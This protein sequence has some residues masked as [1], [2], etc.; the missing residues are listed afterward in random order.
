MNQEGSSGK[1]CPELASSVCADPA[2]A[3][4]L[5]RRSS[6]TVSEGR[7]EWASPRSF[8]PGNGSREA[9]PCLP[10][11]SPGF[12]LYLPVSSSLPLPR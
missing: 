10:S 8:S 7:R 3:V 9:E 6:M 2:W 4:R 12:L 1:V 5:L 11:R